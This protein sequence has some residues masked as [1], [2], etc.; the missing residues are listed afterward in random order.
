VG[1]R[2]A[3]PGVCEWLC[4]VS[5]ACPLR[6]A[7]RGSPCG[8]ARRAPALLASSTSCS[9]VHVIRTLSVGCS[10]DNCYLLQPLCRGCALRRVLALRDV[11]P[12]SPC[13]CA[14]R[15]PALLAS[16]TPCTPVRVIAHVGWRL[17]SFESAT[18]CNPSAARCVHCVAVPCVC[19]CRSCGPRAHNTGDLDSRVGLLARCHLGGDLFHHV[20]ATAW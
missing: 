6:C 10:F 16:S 12:S 14:R 5:C 13:G 7:A 19:L 9:P 18:C 4:I 8:C 20:N 2:S 1:D 17:R 11:L 15:V 3:C